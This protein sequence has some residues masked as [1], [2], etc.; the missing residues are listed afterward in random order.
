MI[1][2]AD[3]ARRLL[4]NEAGGGAATALG[5]DAVE[6]VCGTLRH[7]FEPLIGPLG[8]RVI[9]RR[10]IT[11]TQPKFPFLAA[12]PVTGG[13]PYLRGLRESMEGQDSAVAEEAAVSLLA[14]CF[15]VLLD[16]LGESITSRYLHEVWP[17]MDVA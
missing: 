17:E 6:R 2:E 8:V 3:L 4:A 16:L 7:H 12:D 5:A 9:A 11:I 14:N 10:A 13:D 1:Q 15:G